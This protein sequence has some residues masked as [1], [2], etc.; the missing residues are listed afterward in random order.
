M[1]EVYIIGVSCTPFGKHPGLSFKDL[2][3]QAYLEALADA[4]L[5]DGDRIEIVVAVGGG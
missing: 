3:R 4:G 1:D 2:T 5:A